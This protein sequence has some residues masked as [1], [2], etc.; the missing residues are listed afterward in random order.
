M[1]SPQKLAKVQYRGIS[2][3]KLEEVYL[4]KEERRSL[5]KKNDSSIRKTG[6]F[7]F[8]GSVAAEL[9][10]SLPPISST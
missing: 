7:T 1:A 8:R 3:Q 9:K 2:F 10:S 4:P 6:Q 5:G